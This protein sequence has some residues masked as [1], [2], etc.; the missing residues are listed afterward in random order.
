MSDFLGIDL[1]AGLDEDK[2]IGQINRAIGR[3]QTSSDLN[4]LEIKMDKK[5]LDTIKEFNR[6][7]KKLSQEAEKSGRSIRRAVLVRGDGNLSKS[8]EE[9][10][11]KTK[12]LAREQDRRSKQNQKN[13]R[14]EGE[15]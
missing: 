1:I 14:D 12:E 2:S 3:I 8:I 13:L 7:I 15:A 4:K 6:E 11:K 9:A 5:A 10:T